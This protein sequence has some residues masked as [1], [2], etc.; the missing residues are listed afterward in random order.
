MYTYFPCFLTATF[1][2]LSLNARFEHPTPPLFSTMPPVNQAALSAGVIALSVAVAAAIA[3]Y[4]SPELRRMAD[5][6]RRRIAV[7]LHSLGDG[8]QPQHREPMFNRPEDAEGFMRSRSVAVGAE[9]DTG[10]DADEESRRR[11]R[12]ELMYWNRL[13]TEKKEKEKEK[14]AGNDSWQSRRGSSARGSSFDDF[15][16]ADISGEKGTFV[17]NTGAEVLPQ[18]EGLVFR[19]RAP[20]GVRGLNAS[21]YANP[22]GDE[23]GIELD[24]RPALPTTTMSPNI[25][26]PG[27][28]EAMFDFYN[29]TPLIASP[30]MAA[31]SAPVA[32]DDT[33]LDISH[34]FTAIPDRVANTV[35]VR[36]D[37]VRPDSPP[38]PEHALGENEY[39]TAGQE[40]HEDAYASIQAWAHNSGHEFYSPLPMTPAAPLSEPEVISDGASTPTDS[41]SWAGSGED[42][43]RDDA[44]SERSATEGR[45]YDVVSD[46]EEGIPTPASW[47][48]V[49]SVISES[50]AGAAHA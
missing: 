16:S 29:A 45:Y 20:A 30:N 6:L 48:E 22:F 39:M 36:P 27:Q 42:V 15:L 46:D 9:A 5:D 10:V 7:A 33:V 24:E 35:A 14:E 37:S 26:S 19:G 3:V 11:Q 44:A 40:S 4:E 41:A 49:G 28:D 34:Q 8:I 38:L 13:H 2:L 50:D 32:I 17:F 47:T 23:H 18:E 43:G 21:M 1:L 31:G 12:E 25:L